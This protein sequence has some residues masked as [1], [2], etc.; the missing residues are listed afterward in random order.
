VITHE[1]SSGSNRK[2]HYSSTFD[3]L[4][5]VL[6]TRTHPSAARNVVDIDYG[7]YDRR[8]GVDGG[9]MTF[10]TLVSLRRITKQVSQQR[11]GGALS[12]VGWGGG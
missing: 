8:D 3:A 4:Q 1:P 7:C 9:G 5:G 11:I 10:V 2:V 12:A 6:V